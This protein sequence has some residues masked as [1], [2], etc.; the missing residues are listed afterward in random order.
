MY[1]YLL[2]RSAR[3]RTTAISGGLR[4]A[5]AVAE[6]AVISGRAHA[7]AAWALY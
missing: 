1:T 6:P 4:G 7:A 5:H 2:P 3:A